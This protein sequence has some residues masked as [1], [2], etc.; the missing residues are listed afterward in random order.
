M[1][2]KNPKINFAKA[3][4]AIGV[5]LLWQNAFWSVFDLETMADRSGQKEVVLAA[6]IVSAAVLILLTASFRVR[7]L[8]LIAY[9][10]IFAPFIAA[11]CARKFPPPGAAWLLVFAA[12]LYGTC[13]A[14]EESEPGTVIRSFVPIAAVFGIAAGISFFAGKQID[15]IRIDENGYYQETRQKIRENVIGKV[16]D[17]AENIKNKEDDRKPDEEKAEEK[18]RDLESRN[19][20]ENTENKN[21]FRTEQDPE[22]QSGENET[23]SSGGKMEDLKEIAAFKPSSETSVCVVLEKKTTYLYDRWGTTYQDS[24]WTNERL[25]KIL[26]SSKYYFEEEREELFLQYPPELTRMRKMCEGWDKSSLSAVKKQIDEALSQA[27]YD[28][29]PGST[30]AKW[31]FAEYFLFEN[32]KGFCV[33][34][35]TTAALFYR[36]CGYQSIYVEGSVVP[37]SAFREKENGTYEAQVDGSMGHAWCEVYDEESGEWI[38]ME[39]T[40]AALRNGMEGADAVEQKNKDDFDNAKV[41]KVI[42]C[43]IFTVGAVFGCVFIQA[44]VREKRHRR[45][46]GTLRGGIGILTMYDDVVEIARLT[47]KPKK[48]IF[49]NKYSDTDYYS[50]IRLEHLKK[51]YPQISEE[52]WNGFYEE[53]RRILFYHPTEG[54]EGWKISYKVYRKFCSEAEKRMGQKARLLL[55]YVY[56]I[57]DLFYEKGTSFMKRKKKKEKEKIR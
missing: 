24:A 21:P 32:K 17:L 8:R 18:E 40:P 54:R 28:V 1:E 42:V 57:K 19:E 44:A 45:K 15:R 11:A 3:T 31:D 25:E 36:M 20:R 34:F 43:I 50:E 47:E 35:A 49:R 23:L 41:F 9:F 12:V 2:K 30:P 7:R 27:V 29:N 56:C 13:C 33:H 39:H 53:V 14:M 10:V 5:I 52:E 37:A 46:I 55:K 22:Q 6:V 4:A 26:S 51:Q 38:T 16:E 48:Q